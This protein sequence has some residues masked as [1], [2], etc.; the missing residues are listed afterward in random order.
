MSDSQRRVIETV[1]SA[2]DPSKDILRHYSDG[3]VLLLGCRA[4]HPH[5]ITPRAFNGA[6]G[7]DG[8]GVAKYG[9]VFQMPNASHKPAAIFFKRLGEKMMAEKKIK[10]LGA[11]KKFYRKGEDTS[12]E[13]NVGFYVVN[14][15]E[16]D[17]PRLRAK[18]KRPLDPSNQRDR[19][20]IYGGCWVNGLIQPWFM[21]NKWG[22]RINASLRA[23]QFVRDDTPY[24]TGRISDKDID[25]TF[26]D[27]EENDAGP[28][29]GDDDDDEL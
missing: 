7:G 22:Q 25:D 20:M 19:E 10:M 8:S 18:D 6:D 4:S 16:K 28:M 17:Q 12:S 23:V 24:G 5:L 26:D 9:I 1:K 15:S 29:G 13:E 3:T 14:A 21:D 2:I 27:E 11:D